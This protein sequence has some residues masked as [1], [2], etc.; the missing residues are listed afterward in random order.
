MGISNSR[1]GP[2]SL[3]NLALPQWKLRP[4]VQTD[5]LHVM[6]GDPAAS[7]GHSITMEVQWGPQRKPG[8]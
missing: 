1:K 3:P 4:R 7:M 2:Y 6:C 8:L 5:L